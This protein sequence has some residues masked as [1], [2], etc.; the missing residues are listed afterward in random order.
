MNVHWWVAGTLLVA[1]LAAS[2]WPP[3]RSALTRQDPRLFDSAGEFSRH[4]AGAYT[5]TS[6][7]A[8]WCSSALVVAT[9][10][11]VAAQ[12]VS[13]SADIDT[14]YVCVL[15]GTRTWYWQRGRMLDTIAAAGE[16]G[17]DPPRPSTGGRRRP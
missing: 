1:V 17:H 12:A 10:E 8:G 13:L 4:R 14:A 11:Q 3:W 2:A 5:M 6:V 16:D 9:W 15:R 7:S